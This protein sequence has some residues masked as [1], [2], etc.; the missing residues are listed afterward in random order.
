MSNR[1]G[2][3]G[4]LPAVYKMSAEFEEKINYDK[5]TLI[6]SIRSSSTCPYRLQTQSHLSSHIPIEEWRER[7]DLSEIK[8]SLDHEGYWVTQFH[9]GDS[10]KYHSRHLSDKLSVRTLNKS[11][12]I[13]DGKL[14]DIE[15]K[16]NKQGFRDDHFTDEPGIACFGDSFTFGT[17]I[18]RESTWPQQ[19]ASLLGQ[20]TWNLGTAGLSLDVGTMYALEYM[21]E[22]LPNV[23]GICILEACHGITFRAMFRQDSKSL[24]FGTWHEMLNGRDLPEEFR[25]AFENSIVTTAVLQQ[26]MM[27]NAL[28][29]Y[30]KT[31]NIPCVVVSLDEVETVDWAR[32]LMHRGHKSQTNI[33][34]LFAKKYK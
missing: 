33:A 11:G 16:T 7:L 6:Q 14:V 32:D 24:S 30:A 23:N 15:Y 3:I 9:P 26:R 25:V 10:P 28:K 22:D 8:A 20:K 29:F 31:K 1:I 19:L 21:D 13:K 18:D 27:I 4:Y 17:G 12:W 5:E 34:E 2:W